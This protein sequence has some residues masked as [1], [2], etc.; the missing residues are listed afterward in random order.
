MGRVVRDGEVAMV[1]LVL[2]G[3]WV[4]MVLAVKGWDDEVGQGR[5]DDRIG[6]GEGIGGV[7]YG[8]G[9][10]GKRGCDELDG[11]VDAV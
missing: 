3:G 6:G 10:G 1:C 5:G 9:T 2:R 11:A 4:V 8:K 7:S